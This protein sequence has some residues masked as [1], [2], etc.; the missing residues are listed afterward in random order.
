MKRVR[1]HLSYANVMAT[2]AVFIALGGGAYAAIHLPKNSIGAK[3]LRKNSVTGTKV[4][5]GS[6]TRAD[7]KAGTIPAQGSGGGGGQQAGHEGWHE[8]GAPGEPQ[9]QNGWKN[10]GPTTSVAFYKD[11]E[12]EVHLRGQATGAE[13]TIM[14]Q[15]PPGYRPGP[16]RIID[17][18]VVCGCP[19]PMNIVGPSTTLGQEYQGAVI[20]PAASDGFDGV[21]FPA[22]A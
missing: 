21:S 5:N 3:Q 8:V 6:L 9:F 13:G 2:L 18:Q 17:L 20:P 16:E 14:F 10:T 15:L 4:K 22:E 12:G 7:L 11:Q 1:D 19:E